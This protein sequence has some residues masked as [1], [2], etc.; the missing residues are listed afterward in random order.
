MWRDYLDVIGRYSVGDQL[1]PYFPTHTLEDRLGMSTA[2]T[3][4]T[5]L[6]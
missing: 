3:M 1:L 6:L 2:I 5:S 4:L